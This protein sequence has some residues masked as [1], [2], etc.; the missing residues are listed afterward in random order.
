MKR[1][2]AI[3]SLIIF[4]CSL[5]LQA[6]PVSKDKAMDIASKIFAAQSVRKAGNS[7]LKLVWDGE[8]VATKATQPAFYVI[9]RESGG[10]VIVAGDDNVQPV[11]AISDTNDFT[12]EG[13][14]DNVKWWMERMK[15]YVRSTSGQSP[16]VRDQWAKF[17]GTKAGGAITGTVEN[18]VEHLTPDWGQDVIYHKGKAD[19][20]KIFNSKCPLDSANRYTAAGCVAVAIGEVMTTLSGL[21]S[22]DIMPTHSSGIIEPY[23]VSSGSVS[24]ST[25]EHPY[26]LD[27]EYEWDNLRKLTGKSAI[28]SALVDGNAAWVDNMDQLLADVGAMMHS[29]YGYQNTSAYTNRIP[30][31]IGKYLGFNK[32]AYYESASNYSRH[33][34]RE[35]LK[36]QLAERPII[37]NGRTEDNKAGHAFVFDGYGQ[38]EGADVFHVNFGWIGNCNG[39]YYETNLDADS[40]SPDYNYSWKCGAVFDFYPAPNSTVPIKLEAAYGNE[41]FP[42]VI[43]ELVP[44]DEYVLYAFIKNTGKVA[45]DG[46]VKFAVRKKN[47]SIQDI[48]GAITSFSLNVN[49][50]HSVGIIDGEFAVL[51]P[52]SGISFGDQV[53]CYYKEDMTKADSD[54]SAWRLLPGPIATAI[55]AWPLTP[56]AFIKTESSY[57]LNDWFV[58]ELMNNNYIYPKTTWTITDPDGQTT[59]YQ[60]SDKEFQLTKTG[61][62]KIQAATAQTA[63]T[64][65]ENLVTIITVGS[66]SSSSS[67]R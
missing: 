4:F 19:E 34:W 52:I 30:D 41:D 12:V 48:E 37:Y 47:G 10:F 60:Q 65:L 35:K 7:A 3:T 11:L 43:A 66:P 38:Y 40:E 26:V 62:Y 9:A 21:Y 33:Q 25:A 58:F 44:S 16:V 39:Y 29:F 28:I 8:D 2:L 1:F 5:S 67:N 50:I 45:Y 59:T 17:A 64:V 49:A 61:K 46:K 53:V 18:R 6:A 22:S 13:M 24:A 20:R 55:S 56:S 36:E 63:G 15:A 23:S 54:A 51:F 27:A 42:G 32:G 57:S 31:T 14:P